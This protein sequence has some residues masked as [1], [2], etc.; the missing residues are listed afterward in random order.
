[1]FA[2]LLASGVSVRAGRRWCSRC[3]SVARRRSSSGLSDVRDTLS[4]MGEP[5]D[6]QLL[7]LA[8]RR[9]NGAGRHENAMRDELGL[10]STEFWARVYRIVQAPAPDVALEHGPLIVR[11]RRRLDAGQRQRTPRGRTWTAPRR[12]EV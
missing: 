2:G 6:R 11:L 1:M 5:T 7:E 9:Y 10:S 3:P 12:A 4:R 8:G